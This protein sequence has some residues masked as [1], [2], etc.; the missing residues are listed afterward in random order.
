MVIEIPDGMPITKIQKANLIADWQDFINYPYTQNLGDSWIS[1]A[2]TAVLQVPSAI[3]PEE[4]N[5][6][7][8]PAHADYAQIKLL[9]TEPFEFDARIKEDKP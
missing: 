7:L 5:Y 3:I 9:R 2:D 1:K 8:N 6:L 4:S